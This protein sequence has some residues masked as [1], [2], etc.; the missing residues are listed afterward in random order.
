MNLVITTL[1][2]NELMMSRKAPRLSA[3]RNIL[4]ID[5]IN[6]KN[7]V[8]FACQLLHMFQLSAIDRI[9]IMSRII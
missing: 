4:Q 2:Y 5:T 3:K 1:D 8:F 7:I 9:T 6:L